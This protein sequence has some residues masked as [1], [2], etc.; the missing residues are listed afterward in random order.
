MFMDNDKYA[1]DKGDI[2]VKDGNIS[3]QNSPDWQDGI[4]FN[5]IQL[6]LLLSF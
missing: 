6:R 4:D 3:L 2:F 5:S 1:E